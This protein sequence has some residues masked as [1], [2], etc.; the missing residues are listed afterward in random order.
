MTKW[1]PIETAPKM[2]TILLFAV[3][4]ADEDGRVRNWKMATGFYHTGYE[5]RDGRSPWNWD[6][7]HIASYDVK[8]THWMELPEPPSSVVSSKHHSTQGE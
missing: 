6:G 4:D 3:T 2:R 7:R 8:P 1:H 5:S